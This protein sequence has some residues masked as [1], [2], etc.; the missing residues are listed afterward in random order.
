MNNLIAITIGIGSHYLIKTPNG[1]I[2]NLIIN[3]VAWSF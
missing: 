2:V 1:I 3:V